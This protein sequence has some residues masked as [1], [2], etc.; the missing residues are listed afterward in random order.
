MR[1]YG[2]DQNSAPFFFISKGN[3]LVSTSP[4]TQLLSVRFWEKFPDRRQQFLRDWLKTNHNRFAAPPDAL[5]FGAHDL[6]R[7]YGGTLPPVR[8]DQLSLAPWQEQFHQD[9]ESARIPYKRLKWQNGIPDV[10]GFSDRSEYLQR[11]VDD[12]V[13]AELKRFLAFAGIDF[14]NYR[15][16]D[17]FQNEFQSEDELQGR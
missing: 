7:Q 11:G 8:N 4:N 17:V 10:D 3:L 5:L 15:R 14:D 13:M 2:C 9:T 6:R 1:C 16:R 12:E